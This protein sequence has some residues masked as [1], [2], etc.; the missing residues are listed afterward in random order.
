M[1]IVIKQQVRR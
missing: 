1:F